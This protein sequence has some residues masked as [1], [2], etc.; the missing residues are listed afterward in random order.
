[1][2]YKFEKRLSPNFTPRSQSVAVFGQPRTIKLTAGHWWGDPKAG[3]SHQGVVDTFM[4]PKRQ[5]SSHYVVSA[6]RVTQMVE[7]ANVSWATGSANPYTISIELDPRVY[8]RRNSAEV[9]TSDAILTTVKELIADRLI[10]A[11]GNLEIRAHNTFPN[12]NTACNPINWKSIRDGAYKLWQNRQQPEWL[13]NLKGITPVKLMVLVTQTDIVDLRTSK[14]IKK[15][16]RGTMVDFTKKT[17]VK[18]VEYLVS[19]YSADR[20]IPN[21]IR[22]KDVG[23]PAKPPVSEKPE[24]LQKWADITNVT[25]YTRVTAELIDLET[26]KTIKTI[27]I[28]TPIA[29]DATTERLGVKYAITEYSVSKKLPHGID[30][31]D[32][33][34]KPVP[35]EP[36]TPAPVQPPIQPEP[37]VPDYS[38][39]NNA[40]LV[41]LLELVRW[42]KSAVERILNR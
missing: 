1:M 34:M 25:M 7:L 39:E 8:L 19:K 27:P 5:A 32:L 18:G 33:D 35:K 40:L 6:G 14:S 22:R 21:G 41:E 9:K 3:Y 13:K 20:G 15:L 42:I 38:K 10:P 31:A 2:S 23:V 37:Q 26:G 24:W 29:V 36:A 30:L 4:N 17:T 11:Y 28:R 12:T 16:G